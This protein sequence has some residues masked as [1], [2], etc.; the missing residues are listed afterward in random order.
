MI[1]SEQYAGYVYITEF[2]ISSYIFIV[3]FA[4]LSYVCFS[5]EIEGKY[6]QQTDIQCSCSQ[7]LDYTCNRN[8][9]IV[10]IQ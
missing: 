3:L 5:C 6:L 1:G 9:I 7:F 10:I 8:Y 4:S 2:D